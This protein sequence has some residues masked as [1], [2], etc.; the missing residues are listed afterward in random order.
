[1]HGDSGSEVDEIVVVMSV[2][3]ALGHSSTRYGGVQPGMMLLGTGVEDPECKN[4]AWTPE[5][6]PSL[7]GSD[8]EMH[9]P[10]CPKV[11]GRGEGV[12]RASG[13]KSLWQQGQP[14]SD[15]VSRMTSNELEVRNPEVFKKC[16]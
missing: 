9:H 2:L 3:E 14:D 15:P 13:G 8:G 16:P 11:V 7:K 6:G 10:S 12:E 5:M 1:M 4:F